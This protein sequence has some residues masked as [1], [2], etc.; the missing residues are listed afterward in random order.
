VINEFLVS[1][2]SFN[3][4]TGTITFKNIEERDDYLHS[5]LK[6]AIVH[7]SF[8]NHD[9]WFMLTPKESLS[10]RQTD[11]YRK[12]KSLHRDKIYDVKDRDILQELLI[13]EAINAIQ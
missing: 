12:V 4:L 10:L 7:K 11:D 13:T 3:K 9:H 1:E 2:N 6:I 5:V 8:N